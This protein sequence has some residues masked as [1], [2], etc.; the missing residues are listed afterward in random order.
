VE[1]CAKK[2]DP[3]CRGRNIGCIERV[4]LPGAKKS[5]PRFAK[6]I[7]D[8]E[9]GAVEQWKPPP[10]TKRKR[11]SKTTTP[12]QRLSPEKSVYSYSDEDFPSL[13]KNK[14]PVRMLHPQ[15]QKTLPFFR[16]EPNKPFVLEPAAYGPRVEHDESLPSN[17]FPFRPASRPPAPPAAERRARNRESAPA[18]SG[19]PSTPPWWVQ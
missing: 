2:G 9:A 4:M 13:R 1:T 10:G 6:L 12:K 15:E 8:A 17:V 3:K 7:C 14:S 18:Q 11:A 16:P 19:R 5:V